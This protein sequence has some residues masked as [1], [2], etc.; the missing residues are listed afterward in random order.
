MPGLYMVIYPTAAS[1]DLIYFRDHYFLQTPV[2]HISLRINLAFLKLFAHAFDSY[3]VPDTPHQGHP[4]ALI[5][6]ALC[7]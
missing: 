3:R 6:A 7:R 2:G 4:A 1:T 5:V